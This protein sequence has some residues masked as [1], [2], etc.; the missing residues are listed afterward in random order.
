MALKVLR[1]AR[2]PLA[3]MELLERKATPELLDL[4]E[5]QARRGT[6]EPMAQMALPDL[7]EPQARRDTGAAGA[8]GT[9]GTDGAKGDT[10]AAGAKGENGATGSIGAT[11][12]Q[13]ETGLQGV[14]GNTGATGATG[15][16]GIDGSNGKSVLSG[17]GTPGADTGSDGDFYLDLSSY[18]MFGPK[19][20]SIWPSRSQPLVGPAGPMGPQG[21]A[22]AVGATGEKGNQGEQGFIG[23]SGLQGFTGANGTNGAPGPQGPQGATGPMGAAGPAGP[24]GSSGATV[25]LGSAKFID[26]ADTTGFLALS[27]GSAVVPA[28]ADASTI[29]PATGTISHLN[30]QISTGA[31]V[32][33]TVVINGVPSGASCVVTAPAVSCT[34]PDSTATIAKDLPVALKVENLNG[35]PVR[36]LRYSMAF[37]AR[38]HDHEIAVK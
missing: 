25:F 26:A 1:E 30:V 9:N 5:P 38:P 28:F 14:Q 10:G 16:A 21:L 2:A 29:M 22:G 23:A 31:S 32:K 6:P 36:N 13:G 27:G 34:N 15:A 20:G 33:V 11:G 37:K 18:Q 7:L 4:L 8:A 12:A 3:Q 17:T 24:A 19:A 35:Q